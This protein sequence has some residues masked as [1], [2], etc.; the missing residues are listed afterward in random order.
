MS[1]TPG[2]STAVDRVAGRLAPIVTAPAKV[3]TSA[4]AAWLLYAVPGVGF[5]IF[6][7]L[8]LAYDALRG[9]LPM[10]PFGWRLMG[11]PFEQ[12]GTDRLTPLGWGLAAV[13][14][15]TGLVDLVAA[16]WLRR[17]RR[18]GGRLALATTPISLALGIAFAVPFLLV[19][20]PLRAILVV[21]NWRRLR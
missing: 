10:T 5:A 11:G 4:R 16:M 6:V 9:E 13:L 20:P 8:V 19:V 17:G 18:R 14:V 1:G 2:G 21:A 3:G 15:G 7:P 12:I